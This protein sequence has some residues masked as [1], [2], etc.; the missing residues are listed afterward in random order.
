MEQLSF[1]IAFTYEII[2][3]SLQVHLCAEIEMI[4]PDSCFVR[5]IRRINTK[6]SSLLP[7]LKLKKMDDKWV[8]N[9]SSKESN[10]S[11]AAGEGIDRHLKQLSKSPDEMKD[12]Q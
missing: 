4:T 9:D 1:T 3:E 2:P 7:V 5:N 10:I 6:E 8:H 11:K 12:S